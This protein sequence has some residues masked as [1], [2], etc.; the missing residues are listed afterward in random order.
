M[1]N[2]ALEKWENEA[3]NDLVNKCAMKVNSSKREDVDVMGIKCSIHT[4]EFAYCIWKELFNICPSDKQIKNKQC[5]K[6]RK[7]LQS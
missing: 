4:A 7:S 5:D 1:E 3:S 2:F 6:L